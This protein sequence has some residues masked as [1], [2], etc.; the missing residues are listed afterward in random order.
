M[1]NQTTAQVEGLAIKG[2]SAIPVVGQTLASIA[3]SVTSLFSQ[4][5][6]AAVAKEASTINAALPTFVADVVAVMNAANEGAITQAAAQNYLSQAQG[7]YETTVSG[8]IKD[9]GECIPGCYLTNG[10]NY[11]G[12]HCCNSGSSCNAACC[13][14][15]GVVVPTVLQLKAI[16]SSGKGSWTI[17]GSANNGSIKGTAPTL[18]N[19]SQPTPINFIEGAI[20]GKVSI[21][22]LIA[23][24]EQQSTIRKVAELVIAAVL[25][26][27]IFRSASR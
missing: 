26:M 22:T 19:F 8:I 16:L 13:L 24:V 6:A 4:A 18:I 1:S 23:D 27:V 10:S 14:R 25:L 21:T 17:P 9:N 7:N 5:H 2:I 11:A 15:C 12:T 20:T 3:S